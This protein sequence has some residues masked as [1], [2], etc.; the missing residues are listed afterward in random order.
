MFP[1]KHIQCFALLKYNILVFTTLEK[2][3]NGPR[4]YA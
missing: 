4:W 3:T 1:I 2:M